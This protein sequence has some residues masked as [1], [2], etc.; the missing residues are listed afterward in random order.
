[1]CSNL[2]F[3]LLIQALLQSFNGIS[4]S[5]FLVV[6]CPASLQ[7]EGPCSPYRRLMSV[8]ATGRIGNI[9]SQ[10]ATLF[11]FANKSGYPAAIVQVGHDL[12]RLL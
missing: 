3:K 12:R 1:M 7:V 9:M 4:M 2:S 5:A 6:T 10:Y 8:S 11:S